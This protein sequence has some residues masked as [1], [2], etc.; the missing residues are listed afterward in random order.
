MRKFRNVDEVVSELKP[1]NSIYCIRKN[2]IRTA[3]NWFNKN[4]PGEVLYA[5]KTNPH[6]EVVKEIKN[7]GINK[8]DIASIEEIKIIKKIVPEA[9]CFLYE[10]Y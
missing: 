6:E 2:S 7:S 9:E 8:F 1:V 4:F 3:S 10:H 5:V